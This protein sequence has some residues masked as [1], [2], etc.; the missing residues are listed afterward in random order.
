MTMALKTFFT[1]INSDVLIAIATVKQF[2]FILSKYRR[3]VQNAFYA[4]I[5]LKYTKHRSGCQ[6]MFC[7]GVF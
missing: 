4:K 2:C 5:A 6:E 7:K 3:I 1:F